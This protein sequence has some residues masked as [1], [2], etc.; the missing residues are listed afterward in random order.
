MIEWVLMVAAFLLAAFHS[1]AETGVYSLN[2]L[3]LRLRAEQGRSAARA[4]L[5]LLRR[6]QLTISSLLVGT[7]IGIYVATALATD[8]IR[9]LLPGHAAELYS[10]LIMPPILLVLAEMFPKSLFQKHADVLMYKT[11]WAVRVSQTVFYPA[12]VLLQ[13]VSRLPQALMRTE[14]ASGGRALTAEALR[15]YLNEAAAQGALSGFQKTMAE[16]ILRL[17][18]RTVAEVMTP[19]ERTVMVAEDAPP[20][21]LLDILRRHRYSRIPVYRGARERI[22]GVI[23]VLDVAALDGEPPAPGEMT[24]PVLSVGQTTS[25]ADALWAL[26]RARQQLGAVTDEQG[27]AV[28]IVTI[29]DLVEE[30]VGELA[31]W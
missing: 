17:R 4:L 13:W 5:R 7:N 9:R 29:K 11:V 10:G 18:S 26:R 14:R 22:V 24:R 19:I 1:G 27:R 16:N 12:A 15:F 28:G 30:I 3:R 8:F 23:N 6:P 31:A 20:G 2:R 21:E 25:V